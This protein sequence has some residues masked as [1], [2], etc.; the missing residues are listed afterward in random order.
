MRK[1]GKA[2][3]NMAGPI[4]AGTLTSLSE[5]ALV[6]ML[7]S[8]TDVDCDIRTA[9]KLHAGKN[10][11]TVLAVP[12]M[13][14]FMN[15]VITRGEIGLGEAYADG[16]WLLE[17]GSL[18]D[19]LTDLA[20][21]SNNDGWVQFVKNLFPTEWF[22]KWRETFSNMHADQ[23]KELIKVAYDVDD[24]LYHAM[25]DRSMTYT[26]ARFL[27]GDETLEQAQWHKRQ[28]MVDKA[29]L[30][31]DARVVD[32]G[33]GW[34]ALC[35]HVADDTPGATVTGVSNSPGMV[36]IATERNGKRHNID[37]REC[38]Y[39]DIDIPDGTV[40]AILSCEMVE[41]IGVNQFDTFA[42]VCERLLKPGG[43]A[44][45]QVITAPAWS[46][47]TARTKV[48][49][50]ET[51]VT[52]YIFPGGQIPH[53]EYMEEAMAPYFDRVHSES[54]GHDYARTLNHWRKNLL[55]NQASVKCTDKIKRGYDYYLA[56][57]EAGFATEL[58]N[59]HQLVFQKRGPKVTPARGG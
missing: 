18:A 14:E 38:D 36:R 55:E 3:E 23:Q 58:L 59:I 8:M 41:A 47:P 44:V 10:H 11:A 13:F 39:R 51:F 45:I 4:V 25:L 50:N 29:R 49:R 32:I 19:M 21:K 53:V 24:T 56:W 37:Y 48:K 26:S 46:N 57:C 12:D 28:M 22:R 9:Y 43:R 5:Q 20:R 34:G 15:R 16:V 27:T 17:R 40:D 30:P 33:C 54:F 2:E 7:R 1:D 35:A 52:T 6:Y 42:A 31:S